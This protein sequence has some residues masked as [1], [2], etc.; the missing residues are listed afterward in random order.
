[1]R[2]PDIRNAKSLLIMAITLSENAFPRYPCKGTFTYDVASKFCGQTR[3]IA[4]AWQ[5]GG[6]GGPEIPCFYG[7]DVIREWS[8][9]QL[10]I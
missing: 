7:R 5:T 9:T 10:Q 2:M 8:L 6:G 3:L 1:M 4:A